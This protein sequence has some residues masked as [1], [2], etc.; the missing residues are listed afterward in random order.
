MKNQQKLTDLAY[1]RNGVCGLG[2]YVGIVEEIED[3]EKRQMLVVRFPKQADKET[4]GIVC[5]AFDIAKL[6]E[7]NIAF[8]DNSW[9][10]DHYH[11]TMDKA[12]KEREAVS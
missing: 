4:G 1:H 6:A 8:G 3:G 12:I 10:G 11:I 5:A 2:F 9:R 7:Q